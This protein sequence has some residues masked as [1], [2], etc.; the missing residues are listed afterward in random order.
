MDSCV[1]DVDSAPPLTQPLPSGRSYESVLNH[2]R[3]EKEIAERL[4]T[5][6]R[7]ERKSIYEHMYDELFAKVKDFIRDEVEPITVEFHALGQGRED[8]WSYAPGQLELLNGVKESN[9]RIQERLEDPKIDAILTSSREAFD[10]VER[11]V[12]SAE[13]EVTAILVEFRKAT[14]PLRLRPT[15]ELFEE[16][17]P[18]GLIVF[19]AK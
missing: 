16:T 6:T 12:E 1:T 18:D 4:R 3:V 17:R 19:V 5:A 13:P 8:P 10:S 2:Y 14:V 9:R 7:E 15:G 11:I